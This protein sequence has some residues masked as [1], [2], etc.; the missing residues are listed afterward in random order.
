MPTIRGILPQTRTAFGKH[1]P[2]RYAV[3]LATK[4][5]GKMPEVASKMLALPETG[6]MRRFPLVRST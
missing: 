2:D 1:D 4:A 6:R 5:T 3:R